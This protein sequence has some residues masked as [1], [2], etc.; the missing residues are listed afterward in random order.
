MWGPNSLI[1]LSMCTDP[2]N[3][4]RVTLCRG[5]VYPVPY[6]KRYPIRW[7]RFLIVAV[8][9]CLFPFSRLNS[10]NSPYGGG[11]AAKEVRYLKLVRR[12]HRSVLT[13][14]TREIE[15]LMELTEPGIPIED[16]IK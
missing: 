3:R 6:R 16:H 14:L 2:S 9:L 10:L 11:R 8:A 1:H 12:G 5:V 13:K 15:G 4:K 7:S